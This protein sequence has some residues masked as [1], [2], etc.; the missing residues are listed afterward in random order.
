MLLQGGSK[1][2]VSVGHQLGNY[3][4]TRL[5]GRGGFA[6]VYLGKHIHLDTFAAVKV[7]HTHLSQAEVE[8]FRNEAR[9]IA[10]LTHPNIVRVLDYGVQGTTPFLVMDYAPNGS[11]RQHHPKG[12]SV[13][14]ATIVHYVN[15]TS[16]A[17]RLLKSY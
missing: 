3:Q 8:R 7:L 14:L 10:R 1:M 5:L 6:E 16:C 9:T 17:T 11:L 13:P 2:V 12:L 15:P 4:L